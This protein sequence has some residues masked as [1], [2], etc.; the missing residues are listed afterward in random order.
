MTTPPA[1]SAQLLLY[2][3][4]RGNRSK[5]VPPEMGHFWFKGEASLYL[6]LSVSLSL[7]LRSL[8]FFIVVSCI[9]ESI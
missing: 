3:G 9:G 4:P 5:Q 7:L 1:L 2:Q 8:Y 6:F